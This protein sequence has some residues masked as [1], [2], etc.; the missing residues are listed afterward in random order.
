VALTLGLSAIGCLLPA[1]LISIRFRMLTEING[2]EGV[3]LPNEALGVTDA[4][5]KELYNN[6]DAKGRSKQSRYGLSDFFWYLLAPAHAIHQEHLE[7]ADVRYKITSAVTRKL[8]AAPEELLQELAEKHAAVLFSEDGLGKHRWEAGR[9]WGSWEGGWIMGSARHMFFP[10]F[11]RMIFELVFPEDSFDEDGIQTCTES[12]EN[13]LDAIKGVSRRKMGTRRKLYEYLKAKLNTGSALREELDPQI[14]QEEWALF[15]QGVFFTTGVVQLAEGM[16]HI[17]TALAQHPH[18]MQRLR[19]NPDDDVY[20]SHVVTEALRVWPLFGIAHRITSA[21]IE[22]PNGKLP[23]GSVLCFNYP[24]Y[25]MTGYKQ[26]EEFIPERWYDLK[27]R[28]CNYLPFGPPRNRPC[29]GRRLSLI[30]MKAVTKIMVQRAAFHSCTEH[31]RSLPCGGFMLIQ[32]HQ[33]DKKAESWAPSLQ[34]WLCMVFMRGWLAFTSVSR[35]VM[36]AVNEIYML[37]ESKQLQLA[38]KYFAL[39]GDDVTEPNK[40]CLANQVGHP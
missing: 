15:L 13:V 5:F 23:E 8:C 3:Q 29:P 6:D 26:P 2:E 31:T 21:E 18:V 36:Q 25:H 9:L 34:L 37:R 1:L 27:E 28:N 11:E 32:P 24:K 20:L 16:A 17:S 39:Y 22:V 30:W 19:D 33:Q 38:Q 10:M 7:S 40:P 35:T 4:T 12:A 14:S